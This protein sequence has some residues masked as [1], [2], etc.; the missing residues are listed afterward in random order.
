MEGGPLARAVAAEIARRYGVLD[1]G[2]GR[3]MRIAGA[4]LV[5]QPPQRS[6]VGRTIRPAGKERAAIGERQRDTEI[7]AGQRAGRHALQQP[8]E[9]LG[10]RPAVAGSHQSRRT[11]RVVAR[12]QGNAPM[13]LASGTRP[14]DCGEVLEARERHVNSAR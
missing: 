10:P 14:V 3:E 13:P 6:R 12:R 1:E 4:Q 9:H 5:H 2:A 11:V 7:E 8:L